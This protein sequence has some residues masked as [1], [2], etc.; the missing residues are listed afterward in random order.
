MADETPQVAAPAVEAG[1]PAPQAV[2][3]APVVT[4]SPDATQAPAPAETA[5]AS[6]AEKLWAGKYKAPEILEEAYTHAQAE[7]TRMAQELASLRKQVN[8]RRKTSI[9]FK[10]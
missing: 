2:E 9:S 4:A 5:P 10:I 7:A 8:T 1:Q 6:P 3:S